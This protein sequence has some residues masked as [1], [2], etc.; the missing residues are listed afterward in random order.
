M[1]HGQNYELVKYLGQGGFG[2][3]YEACGPDRCNSVAVKFPRVSSAGEDAIHAFRNE[4]IAASEITHPNVVQ[5]LG[6]AEN[7]LALVMEFVPGGTLKDLMVRRHEEKVVLDKDEVI[8]IST[9]L[10]HG[11][12][13]INSRFLHRDLHPGN[14]LMSDGVPK[15]TD[16]GL[17]KH[18]DAETQ[19]NTFKGRQHICYMAPEN[20]RGEKNTIHGDMYS[21]GL[22]LF[23]L[24]SLEYPFVLTIKS[25]GENEFRQAHAF[26][27]PKN[28][29]G[30]RPDVPIMFI[31]LVNK[32][33]EKRPEDR[34]QSWSEIKSALSHL[35]D[36][37]IVKKA[38][39]PEVVQM[40]FHAERRKRSK[41]EADA[42]VQESQQKESEAK[43]AAATKRPIILNI[44]WS[45]VNEYNSNVLDFKIEVVYGDLYGAPPHGVLGTKRDVPELEF[46]L[47]NNQCIA[48]GFL[49]IGNSLKLTR[50][51][52]RLIGFVHGKNGAG[53][54]YLL[55]CKEGD[56][57][58][59][60][61]V[62][63][64][65]MRGSYGGRHKHGNGVQVFGFYDENDVREIETSDH[66]Y[67][68]YSLKYHQDLAGKFKTFLLSQMA[69]DELK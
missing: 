23:E 6:L 36:S 5:V 40:I 67:H 14:I 32:M 12:A 68:V 29:A 11:V 69:L 34:F 48:I 27:L 31:Q 18:V 30:A 25:P 22:I 20:W 47:P 50:G 39:D 42:K 44:A 7:P 43:Q 3:V 21:L 56:P 26:G 45:A 41:Q 2:T 49:W 8:R 59:E 17:S 35:A 62:C 16:F 66:T 9:A 60:W 65:S 37:T 33:I 61:W 24:A 64:V 19:P 53:F 52:C 51:E 63:E 54:N 57:Y 38:V 13:E 4:V 15:I 46:H 58:G 10:I 55:C 28:L 1:F